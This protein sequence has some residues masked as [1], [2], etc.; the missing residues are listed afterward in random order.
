MLTIRPY[1]AD[2]LNAVIEI[3]LAAWEPVFT[4]FRELLG[5]QIFDTVY[6]DWREEKRE[7]LTSQCSG[8][9][10]AVVRIAELDGKLVGYTVYYCNHVTTIGEISHNAVDPAYQNQ[11]IA[12]E[13][14]EVCLDEMKVKGMTC[15]Q[16]ST[17]GDSSHAPAR[18]A[19]EKAGFDRSIPSV[20]YYRSL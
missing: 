20:N 13:M 1:T 8:E 14:Y 18:R 6:P 5:K 12:T 19:Y 7:Q 10:G 15:A 4:S 16:V 17:G 9:H 3:T 2:D 11:G